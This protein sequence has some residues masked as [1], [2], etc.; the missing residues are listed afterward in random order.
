MWEERLNEFV[1]LFLVINP[2]AVLPVFLA[3]AGALEPAA[4]RKVALYAVAVS[5]AVLVF[6]IVA[7]GF[8]LKSMGIALTAFQISGGI[9][10]FLLALAMVRG[11]SFALSP[12]AARRSRSRS[13]RWPFPRSPAPAPC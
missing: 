10:L 7:G 5:L 2:I 12:A 11:D 1:T 9:V 6:F 13:I 4:Q 8:L 3:V